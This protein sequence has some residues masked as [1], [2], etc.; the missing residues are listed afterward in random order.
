MLRH[1]LIPLAAIAALALWPLTAAAQSVHNL[2]RTLPIEVQDTAV[3]DTG[4]VQIQGSAVNENFAET[5]RLTLEPNVQWGFAENAHLFIYQPNYIGS[6]S[7]RS[8]SG[9][10]HVGMLYNF[11]A[12][13]PV[14][15]SLALSGEVVAPTGVGSDGLDW[16]LE[17]I[18]DKQI[19]KASSE[20]RIHLN[21]RW[22]HNSV[23]APAASARIATST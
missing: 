22:D 13:G 4:K 20:D 16:A 3:T 1:G 2:E 21:I 6:E 5:H 23:P 12:E 15:P 8:G 11:L 18:A 9:D 10:I 19:T 17:F 14:I 7:V